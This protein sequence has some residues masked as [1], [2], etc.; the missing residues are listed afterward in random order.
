VKSTLPP[1]AKGKGRVF[2]YRPS[3]FGFAIKA[4]VIIDNQEVGTSRGRGFFD[5][6]QPAGTR[7]IS[8][9]TEWGHG[10]SINVIAGKPNF[11]GCS[12]T[13]GVL[14]AHILPNQVDEATGE[15]EIQDCKLAE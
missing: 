12:V 7:Q 10:N 11:V 15:S 9:K 5:T 1:I 8:I 6:D 13:P 2:V 14:M 4:P 3:S